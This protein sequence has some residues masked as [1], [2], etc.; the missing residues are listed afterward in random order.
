[1]ESL[2][3]LLIEYRNTEGV[4]SAK[5]L[6]DFLRASGI[7]GSKLP[8]TRQGIA[9]IYFLYSFSPA[10]PITQFLT[11]DSRSARVEM[12]LR[13]LPADVGQATANN[14]KVLAE[15]RFPDS[16]VE[17]GGMGAV[18]HIIHHEI[19]S[20]LI[21]G[22]WNALA[23]IILIL[24]IVFRSLR[25]SLVAAIPNLVPPIL[26]LGFLAVTK[27]PIKPGVAIIFSI[28]LGL[29]FNNTL[30]ALNRLRTLR[31]K[32]KPMPV[33]KTF[34]YEA[35]PCMVSTLVV[36]MGFSVFMF[37]YFSLN[38]TFGICMIV[39][40]LAGVLGDL[41]FLPALL[42]MAPWLLTMEI[43][44]FGRLRDKFENRIREK[45]TEKI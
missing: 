4:G 16:A 6:P 23:I 18:I 22:F 19:S 32:T 41:I 9:E 29:A 40:I 30:F 1:M 5:S 2:D 25:W 44:F 10:N 26:L 43:P 21:F 34:Y 20:D 14:L 31:T 11:N 35:N 42:K 24:T 17:I 45:A 13:D 27:T 37:S 12:K 28:A 36:M 39:A 38:R 3:Q 8:A 7:E 33:E 15:S